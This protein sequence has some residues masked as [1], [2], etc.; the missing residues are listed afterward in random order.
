MRSI[1]LLTGALFSGALCAQTDAP[2]GK[3]TSADAVA[4]IHSLE[5]APLARGA[6]AIRSN[7]IDWA[8]ETKDVTITVCD[9]LGPIPGS[10]VAYGPELLVQA[11]LGNGA[12]QL[13]HPESKG[14]E[15]KVQL[16]GIASMLRAYAKI[17][18]L[19]A[20]ARIPQF[21]A[22]LTDLSDGKLEEQLAPAIQEK[23]INPPA[24]A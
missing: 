15:V 18:E 17:L 5:R 21:D 16:A 4:L 11:M 2:Q 24:K 23:C 10:D 3:V 6:R 12:F 13:Q 22:W 14:D 20:S 9:V 19:D 1:V 7:L 8:Q